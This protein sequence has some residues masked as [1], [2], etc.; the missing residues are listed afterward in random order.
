VD[1]LSTFIDVLANLRPQAV[2]DNAADMVAAAVLAIE[3]LGGL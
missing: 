2:I 1:V 3:G